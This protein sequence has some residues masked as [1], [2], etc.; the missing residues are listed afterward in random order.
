M[1]NQSRL[2]TIVIIFLATSI[3][4][5]SI[6]GANAAELDI[7][8]KAISTISN[9]VGLDTSKYD[10]STAQDPQDVYKDS[11]PREN[12][13]AI[14]D[15]TDSRVEVLYCFINGAIEK[16]Y[17]CSKEGTPHMS[18][19]T[20]SDTAMAQSFLSQYQA[21][22]KSPL[23]TELTSVLSKTDAT[24]NVSTT[25]GNVRLN[26]TAL[27]KDTTFRW[28]YV[29]DGI[30]APDKSVIL[31]YTD[32]FLNYFIDDWNLYPIGSTTVNLSEKAAVEIAMEKAK[33]YSPDSTK[34]GTIGGIKFNV[35]N[36]IVI[37]KYLAPAVYAGNNATRSDNPLEL[38]PM[39]NVWVSLDK[40]YPGN[41]YGFNVYIWA[42]TKEAYYINQRISTIDPPADLIATATDNIHASDNQTVASTIALNADNLVILIT[43]L[44]SAVIILVTL[45]AYLHTKRKTSPLP[46]LPNSRLSKISGTL[47]CV[48]ICTPLLFAVLA[49]P[50]AGAN[51]GGAAVWGSESTGSRNP[52]GTGESWRKS[53]TEVLWQQR[54]ASYIDWLLDN[55]GYVSANN[56]GS[57]NSGSL[58]DAI[59]TKVTNLEQSYPRYAVIDFDHGVGNVR[60]GE[61]HYMFEDNRGTITGIAYNQSSSEP[62]NAVYDNTLY[63][64]TSGKA[65]FAFINTCMSANIT[66]YQYNDGYGHYYPV[67]Q[68]GG[69]VNGSHAQGMPFAWTHRQVG[70]GGNSMSNDG[71]GSTDNGANCYIGFS[72]GSTALAQTI[73]NSDYP[74]YYWVYH[75]FHYA[76]ECDYSIHTALDLASQDTFYYKPSFDGTPLH[77]GFTAIWRMWINN[78]WQ[79]SWNGFNF[80]MPNCH[81]E[82]YGNTGIKLYQPLI[83]LS[84]SAGAS[85]TFTINGQSYSTGSSYRLSS[86]TYSVNVN[87]IPGKTFYSFLY[88]GVA[89]TSRP[90]NIPLTS[91]GVLI[92][93][94]I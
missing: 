86:D 37:E 32:G 19:I 11:L 56:Q 75:F 63:N 46:L 53:N 40:F 39:Y 58:R 8:Q 60:N 79:D 17:V 18:K 35:T 30:E 38:F 45:P 4:C 29:I 94:Y 1:I 23:Y 78:A 70:T 76:V 28:T 21:Q 2:A 3:A 25:I 44:A 12:I 68:G 72:Y 65:F 69:L 71:Y 88:N 48:I 22:T 57:N 81:M 84:A 41:V 89:Y 27:E 24:K 43:V 9:V 16:I 66:G 90:A 54:T 42:D 52:P 64:Y 83:T 36:A 5:T 55:N 85:P 77:D 10:I 50:V 13:R 31:R 34:I 74:Y 14:L 7:Q 80:I 87:N 61:Y 67:T 15:T 49:E 91:N 59:L 51:V 92:A 93:N 82:I 26:I 20:S 6:S 47:L 73:V 62:D 33:N